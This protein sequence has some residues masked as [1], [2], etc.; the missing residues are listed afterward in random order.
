ME[1]DKSL[2]FAVVGAGAVGCYFGGMLARAGSP[3]TLIGRAAHVDAIRAMACDYKR[4]LL[5]K[6]CASMQ[7]LMWPL[8]RV[9]MLYCSA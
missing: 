6:W 8:C 9:P 7:R 2:R 4:R 5:M 3:V 1:S